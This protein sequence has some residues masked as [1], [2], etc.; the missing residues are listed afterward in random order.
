MPFSNIIHMIDSNSAAVND[1]F[2]KQFGDMQRYSQTDKQEIDEKVIIKKIH[3]DKK[4]YT[5]GTVG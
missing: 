4:L 2:L 5:E 3:L 1:I